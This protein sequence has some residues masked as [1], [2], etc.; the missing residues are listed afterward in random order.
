[1]IRHTLHGGAPRDCIGQ[2]VLIKAGGQVFTGGRCG[3]HAGRPAP[4]P[5]EDQSALMVVHRDL[6]LLD[7]DAQIVL[8]E[9]GSFKL[10]IVVYCKLHGHPEM[11]D[12]ILLEKSAS[13]LCNDLDQRLCLHPLREI[14]NCYHTEPA[15]SGGCR[16]WTNK[17]NAPL[18][19]GPDRGNGM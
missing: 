8:F 13:V 6:T 11:A 19:Q 5:F 14:F 12:N 16:E 10:F 3:G 1:M 15:P 2:P 18:S 17:V 4:H 7:A 9:I